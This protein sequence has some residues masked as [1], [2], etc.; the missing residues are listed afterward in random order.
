MPTERGKTIRQLKCSVSGISILKEINP[1]YS[2]E[3]LM[4][5]LSSSTLATW[6]EELTH[7]KR[8]WSW[9]R[10]KAEKWAEEEMTGERY[11]LSGHEFE[12][13]LGDSRGQ[14]SLACCSPWGCRVR[15]NLGTEQ[16]QVEFNL[17]QDSSIKF[18]CQ[19]KILSN[20]LAIFFCYLLLDTL[21]SFGILNFC[22][23]I[24][25][26]NLSLIDVFWIYFPVHQS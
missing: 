4:L 5:K 26:P 17:L 9:E 10:L 1:K 14:G 15:R 23:C 16:G 21:Y 8:P 24:L 20:C 25:F 13:T 12:Q 19:P 3:G 18:G 22:V 11:W 7:W 6:C 2:L